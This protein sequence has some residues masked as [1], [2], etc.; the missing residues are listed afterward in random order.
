LLFKL[1][2]PGSSDERELCIC[3]NTKGDRSMH[4]KSLSRVLVI[5]SFL[6]AITA[7]AVNANW[8]SGFGF[9]LLTPD[10]VASAQKTASELTAPMM[11][12]P[13]LGNYAGT[14]VELSGNVMIAPDAAPI[15]TTSV[16]VSTDT[17]F[18]GTFAASPTTG[19]VMATDA[20]PV[21]TYTVT[22]TAFGPGGTATKTFALTVTSTP[23]GGGFTDGFTNGAD[24]T[25]GS[26]PYGVAVGD[27]NG[28]GRQDLAVANFLSDTVSIRL[29]DGFGGFSGST[30]VSVG[31]HPIKVAI[32]DFNGDGKQDLAA[33]NN[34][35]NTISIRLGDGLGGFS[36][37]TNVGV[38]FTPENVAI[39][40]FN[41]DGKQD[42]AVAD[43][44][45][46]AVSIR[47][48]NGLGGF[49]GSNIGEGNA[50]IA[51]A[52]GDFNGDGKQDIAVANRDSATVSI[53]LGDGLGGFSG[54][55]VVSAG[56]DPESLSIGDF[57]GDGNQDLAIA[58]YSSATV[59]I[60]LGDG[61]GGFSGP[62]TVGVAALV[63][64]IGDFNRDG[65]QDLAT[66]NNASGSSG[67]VLIRLGDGLGGFSG[68]SEVSVG[69]EPRS[70][71]TGDFNG[72]G[73][74]DLAVANFGSNTVS[75]LLGACTAPTTTSTATN[76]PTNTPTDTPAN[77]A[78]N[79]PTN[80]ATDTPTD[81]P[82]YTAT[83]T[84]TPAILCAPLPT[85]ALAWY[86]GEGN[87]NDFL[88]ANNPVGSN[89]VSFV[90]GK[91]GQGFSFGSLGYIDIAQSASLT[92]ANLTLEAWARPDGAGPNN[93]GFGNDMIN[94]VID[95]S[96]GTAALNWRATDNRFLFI[97]GD[98]ISDLI[99]STDQFPPGQFYHVAATFDGSSAELYVN[100]QLQG[101]Q[102][103]TH[104]LVYNSTYPWVIGSNP[105]RD[106]GFPRTWNGVI[107]EPTIYGRALSAQEIR[108]IYS[109]G[110][111]GKCVPSATPTPTDTPTNTPTPLAIVSGTVTYG[112]P[113]AGT[114][115][116]GVPGVLVSAAG[117]SPLSDTTAGAGT[118]SL[119]GFGAGSYTLMPTK[120]GGQN[121]SITSFDAARIAQYVTGNTSFTAAQAAVADVSG[122]GGISSFDAA[123]IGRYAAALGAPTG[124]TGSWIF[125]PLSYTHASITADMTDDFA[126]FLMGDVSGN[127]GD[128][129]PFRAVAGPERSTAVSAPRVVAASGSDVTVPIIV[130]GAA[131]KG[132]ISYEFDLRYDPSVIQPQGAFLRGTVS[133]GLTVIMN[134]QQPG[135]LRVVVYGATPIN[136]N[137]VL[138]NL[139]FTAVGQAGAISP[140]TWER[141]VFNE[142][143]P[144]TTAANGQIELS[145]A[146]TD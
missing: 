30:E 9:S 14:T 27:F 110:G 120:S 22:V 135:L 68:S 34:A 124:S 80:T 85:N 33:A 35:S 17:N 43:K 5:I 38:A 105:F 101:Q 76:S 106:N 41:G 54:S 89:A 48:G 79:T 143:D 56:S 108:G 92:P 128:P 15:D 129:S 36:G 73:K 86:P 91:V 95:G 31:S 107:D 116:R 18:K 63:I 131:N 20:H 93:D 140:L 21:G 98:D 97:F 6:V 123:L 134:A 70:V 67:R 112:N 66:V 23:C 52:I 117:S 144:S 99:L 121:G 1:I 126:G 39:G 24:V 32:G 57:N 119:T 146:M 94:K 47:L 115:P 133:R 90:P 29:G 50:P 40:D 46:N 4:H 42:L 11:A 109:A 28:D 102:A 139:G 104:G 81:T 142:G 58:N 8:G 78:T 100:G 2:L 138:L 82:T 113:V 84:P 59:S 60:R 25:S 61:L 75:I 88:G 96:S 37:S 130:Q 3:K 45:S 111:A 13:I 103:S 51:L 122:A 145:Y 69:S 137:G 65:N 26:N 55:T 16:T 87:T 77:T 62:T 71:A 127:W 7:I 83:A 12:P 64:A 72:D 136:S 44:N 10:G 141:M 132:I 74:Q 118:Y 19:V 125:D 53:R 49:S 114:N